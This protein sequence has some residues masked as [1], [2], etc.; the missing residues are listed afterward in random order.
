[1]KPPTLPKDETDQQLHIR[2]PAEIKVHLVQVSAQT[3]KSI[4]DLVNYAIRKFLNRTG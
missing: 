2:V 1:M 3:G 4:N